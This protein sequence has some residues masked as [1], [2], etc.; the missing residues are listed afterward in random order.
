MTPRQF[1]TICDGCRDIVWPDEEDAHWGCAGKLREFVEV[2]DS[3]EGL[4]GIARLIL[5]RHY[6]KDIMPVPR[7]DGRDPGVQLVTALRAVDEANRGITTR[8]LP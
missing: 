7:N 6:P 2:D 4:L 1:R 3:F 5:D 8:R